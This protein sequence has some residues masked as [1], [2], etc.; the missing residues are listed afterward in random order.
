MSSRSRY[1]DSHVD[2]KGPGDARPTA[3]SVVEDEGLL[4][5]LTEKVIL[6]TGC[7]SGIGLETAR[8]LHATGAHIFISARNLTKAA[9]AVRELQVGGSDDHGKLDILKLD[10]NSLRSVRECAG[11]FLAKSKQL[12]ILINNAGT[13]F[14]SPRQHAHADIK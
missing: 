5:K 9:D 11:A 1:A 2:P 4:G 6:I 10:L 12:N 13:Y 14:S 8:A 3:R 7:T